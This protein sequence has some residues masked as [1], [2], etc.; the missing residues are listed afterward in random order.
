VLYAEQKVLKKGGKGRDEELCEILDQG[1]PQEQIRPF[2]ENPANCLSEGKENETGIQSTLGN[3]SE[4][5]A[6]NEAN[7]TGKRLREGN[8]AQNT[9]ESSGDSQDGQFHT[10]DSLARSPLRPSQIHINLRASMPVTQKI[11]PLSIFKK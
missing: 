4:E 7:I 10:N 11:S 8:R 1:S 3:D 6:Y 2:E 5:F 9:D